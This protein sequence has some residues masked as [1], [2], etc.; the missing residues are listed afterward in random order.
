MDCENGSLEHD[1]TL[2]ND[3]LNVLS[4]ELTDDLEQTRSGVT[5]GRP[6]TQLPP[7]GS[8]GPLRTVKFRHPACGK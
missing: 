2:G 7:H 1:L 5:R 3:V 6:H 4:V 8:Y